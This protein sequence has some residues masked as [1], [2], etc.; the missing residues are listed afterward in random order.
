MGGV[1]HAACCRRVKGGLHPQGWVPP[2]GPR[3]MQPLPQRGPHPH[4]E[5]HSPRSMQPLPQR[6]SFLTGAWPFC[7]IA[8]AMLLQC[9]CIAGACMTRSGPAALLRCDCGVRDVPGAVGLARAG[10]A[11]YLPLRQ[12]TRRGLPGKPAC[13]SSRHAMHQ[14]VQAM[15]CFAILDAIFPVTL[16]AC[17][18]LL[19]ALSCCVPCCAPCCVVHGLGWSGLSCGSSDLDHAMAVL[20]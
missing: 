15:P 2:S 8:I 1:V 7:R 6:E 16:A 18:V 19:R 17:L 3:S 13:S 11:V 4:I 9:C 10:A 12:D 14:P 20:R 5:P